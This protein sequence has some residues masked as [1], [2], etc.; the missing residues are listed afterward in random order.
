MIFRSSESYHLH[1]IHW[2]PDGEIKGIVVIAH[3]LAEHSGRYQHVAEYLNQADYG[4]YA[5][6][7]YGH[8]QS[9]GRRCYFN[10]FHQP[11]R[12]LAQFIQ[13]V[14]AQHPDQPLWVY[15][16]SMGALI[17]MLLILD[18]RPLVSGLIL[19]GVPIGLTEKIPAFLARFNRWVDGIAPWLPIAPL[20][21]RSLSRNPAVITSYMLDPL[22]Y[23]GLVRVRMSHFIL[24]ESARARTRLSEIQLPLLILHGWK[25]AICPYSGSR[26]L[27][28]QASSKDR[29]LKIYGSMHHEIHQEPDQMEVLE[30]VV[31]WLNERS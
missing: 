15:G 8:G 11:V 31:T 17:S 7:H 26:L 29:Q 18:H 24:A 9:D 20:G 25:D 19:S 5:L 12:D 1:T 30:D 2:L 22:V 28:D 4:V 3:G 10:D 14:Q 6:D 21:I 27:Y 16:H 23:I 13:F